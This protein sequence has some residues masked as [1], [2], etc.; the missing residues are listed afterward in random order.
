MKNHHLSKYK[1][2]QTENIFVTSKYFDQKKGLHHTHT[3]QNCG[4]FISL[5]FAKLS[6]VKSIE[7]PD[8]AKIKGSDWCSKK[9]G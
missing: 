9:I 4:Y 7:V 3:K 2:C 8:L 6:F 1:V 5:V